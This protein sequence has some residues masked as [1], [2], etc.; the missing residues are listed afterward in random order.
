[1]KNENRGPR[2]ILFGDSSWGYDV[3]FLE[4]DMAGVNNLVKRGL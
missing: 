1:M 2:E 3:L 4:T